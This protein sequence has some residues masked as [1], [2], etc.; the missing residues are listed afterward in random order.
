MRPPRGSL[1]SHQR[2]SS[3]EHKNSS[4]WCEYKDIFV[5]FTSP[6]QRICLVLVQMVNPSV[7]A[8]QHIRWYKTIATLSTC[9]RSQHIYDA[10]LP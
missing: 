7:H 8:K 2:I 1:I 4:I 9:G 6:S 3:K 5:A 10:P